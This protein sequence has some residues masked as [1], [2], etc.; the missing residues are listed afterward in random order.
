MDESSSGQVP[1]L[2]NYI[3][4]KET[5]SVDPTNNLYFRIFTRER[6]NYL[7][8]NVLHNR[9]YPTILLSIFFIFTVIGIPARFNYDP[10]RSD[11]TIAEALYM[12]CIIVT[13][14]I[15]GIFFTSHVFGA[16]LTAI[17]TI[18]HTFD[19]WFKM[20]NLILSAISYYYLELKDFENNKE[21]AMLADQPFIY[22]LRFWLF[23]I[24]GAFAAF[25]FFTI[26]SLRIT[27]KWKVLVSIF[28]TVTFIFFGLFYYFT[29]DG[30]I[31]EY[32]PFKSFKLTSINFK[33]VFISS[34]INLALF[35][36][37]PLLTF[38]KYAT[39]GCRRKMKAK[40]KSNSNNVTNN[41]NEKEKY[42]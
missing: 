10:N 40:F 32:N 14:L 16:N 9:T 21:T 2:Q 26:D 18:L 13:T 8:Y 7:F 41:A 27:F 29:Y 31:V 19:F 17:G 37:K 42:H 6:A 22:W 11:N 20:Y 33:N 1:Q 24:S 12:S 28:A 25:V 23:G 34:T 3:A 35:M 36:A 30:S 38:F 5:V 4:T 39:K 15:V